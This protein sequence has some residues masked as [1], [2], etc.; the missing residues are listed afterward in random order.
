[1]KTVKIT[2]NSYWSLTMCQTLLEVLHIYHF[3]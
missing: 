2:V 1:M 3:I